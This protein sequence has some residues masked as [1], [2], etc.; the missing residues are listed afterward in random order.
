MRTHYHKLIRDRIPEI[1]DAAG[2]GYQL[3]TLAGDDYAR[4]LREKLLEEATEVV[5]AGDRDALLLELADLREVID[6]LCADA[7]VSEAELAQAQRQRR[8]ERGAFARRLE[9]LWTEARE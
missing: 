9:L 4:A 8:A 2:V 7:G 1:M 3:G 6:A 5:Q